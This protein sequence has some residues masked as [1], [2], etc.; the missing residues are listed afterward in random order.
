MTNE[1]DGKLVATSEDSA[2]SERRAFLKKVGVAAGGVL[3]AA[4]LG[5]EADAQ[6]AQGGLLQKAAS[7]QAERGRVSTTI[8]NLRQLQ[9]EDVARGAIT[10]AAIGIAKN[11][12]GA[13]ADFGLS[14]TLNWF[15]GTE[16]SGR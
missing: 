5:S 2:Q 3:A 15:P 14:F 8:A 1:E 9:N 12:G 16:V 6:Q 4:T 10:N 7:P 11:L 13:A